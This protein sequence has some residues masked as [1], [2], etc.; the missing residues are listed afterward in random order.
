MDQAVEYFWSELDKNVLDAFRAGDTSKVE[1]QGKFVTPYGIPPS[2]ITGSPE[3]GHAITVDLGWSNPDG[4]YWR[5]IRF[6][7]EGGWV[8]A[9]HVDWG[10]WSS[11]RLDHQGDR[12]AKTGGYHAYEWIEQEIPQGLTTLDELCAHLVAYDDAQFPKEIYRNAATKVP[13]QKT[14]E[15]RA[16]WPRHP[17]V[18]LFDYWGNSR[19]RAEMLKDGTVQDNYWNDPNN[20]PLRVEGGARLAWVLRKK[21]VLPP[22]AASPGGGIG[23]VT[24][25]M[26]SDRLLADVKEYSQQLFETCAQIVGQFRL[27]EHLLK[28]RMSILQEGRAVQVAAEISRDTVPYAKDPAEIVSLLED[29]LPKAKDFMMSEPLAGA[30]RFN[31]S[32]NTRASIDGLM[33]TL[34]DLLFT[35]TYQKRLHEWWTSMIEVERRTVNGAVLGI[36]AEARDVD[37]TLHERLADAIEVYTEAAF[38]LD[39]DRGFLS[40]EGLR[41]LY[42]AAPEEGATSAQAVQ[43]KSPF[44]LA[45]AKGGKFLST[46]RKLSKVGIKTLQSVVAWSLFREGASTLASSGSTVDA[47]VDGMFKRIPERLFDQ[48]G[49]EATELREAA[50]AAMVGRDVEAAKKVYADVVAKVEPK[51]A[52]TVFKVFDM[53]S[54]I[55]AFASKKEGSTPVRALAWGAHGTTVVEKTIG[56]VEAILKYFGKFEKLAKTLAKVG[57]WV[58][59]LAGAANLALGIA[60]LVEVAGRDDATGIEIVAASIKVA[61]ATAGLVGAVLVAFGAVTGGVAFAFEA[62]GAALLL[63]AGALEPSADDDD[64][65]PPAETRSMPEILAERVRWLRIHDI[66]MAFEKDQPECAAHMDRV[67]ACIEGVAGDLSRGANTCANW[68]KLRDAGFPD[69]EILRL[70]MVGTDGRPNDA[71]VDWR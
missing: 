4:E 5:A 43:G 58:G 31:S 56:A 65:R 28:R 39:A 60:Q 54:A 35:E 66:W 48:A 67:A 51:L 18:M 59:V 3:T 26:M 20:I 47:F 61:G 40:H 22:L 27:S 13:R 23:L 9:D 64:D 14:K 49:K 19:W 21:R 24:T 68:S 57:A 2:K 34:H 17:A 46:A 45:L 53:I 11:E 33:A 37:S 42:D 36:D 15:L 30:D 32:Q 1:S 7:V 44:E 8:P 12:D 62:I 10:D 29:V 69:S 50:R 55:V 16:V 25:K 63:L 38:Q 41:D 70:L 52:K 6:H 71:P